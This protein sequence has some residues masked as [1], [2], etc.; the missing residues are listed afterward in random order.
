MVDITVAEWCASFLTCFHSQKLKT[1]CLNDFYFYKHHFYKRLFLQRPRQQAFTFEIGTYLSATRIQVNYCPYRYH[2]CRFI[3]NIIHC[4]LAGT[5]NG[6]GTYLIFGYD[7]L[8]QNSCCS[9]LLGVVGPSLKPSNFWANNSQHF[10]PKRRATML[11]PFLQLL[12]H[13]WGHSRALHMFTKSSGLYSFHDALQ[14]PIL[15]GVLASVS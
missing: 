13:C 8:I 9:V 3:V 14:V 10:F 15:F 11:D 1:R 12:R 5:Y 6:S 7:F 4:D 2:H